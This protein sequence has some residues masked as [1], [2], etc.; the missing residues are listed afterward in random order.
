MCLCAFCDID[1]VLCVIQSLCAII[2]MEP[3]GSSGAIRG[4]PPPLTPLAIFLRD[5]V[6]GLVK[7]N[8]HGQQLLEKLRSI[9]SYTMEQ[10]REVC[11]GGCGSDVSFAMH[12]V[13]CTSC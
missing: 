6:E 10:L 8:E 3:L 11:D 5:L 7:A 1:G 2:S 4:P 13:L 12:A 9:D